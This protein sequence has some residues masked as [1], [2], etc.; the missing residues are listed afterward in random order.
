MY[1]DIV[2]TLASHG[3]PIQEVLRQPPLPS[4]SFPE[5]GGHAMAA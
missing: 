1:E 2:N 3:S 4:L 5:R